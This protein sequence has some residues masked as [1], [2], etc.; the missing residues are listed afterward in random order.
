MAKP[1]LLLVV[2]LA[3]VFLLA[4][5]LAAVLLAGGSA[6]HAHSAPGGAP[7]VVSRPSRVPMPLGADGRPVVLEPGPAR[8]AYLASLRAHLPDSLH[9][10]KRIGAVGTVVDI[11]PSLLRLRLPSVPPAPS[12]TV[13]GVEV[14]SSIG[15]P[16]STVSVGLTRGT[17]FLV[18]HGLQSLA[19][20]SDLVV[21]GVREAEGLRAVLVTDLSTLP[22]APQGS[23]TASAVPASVGSPQLAASRRRVGESLEPTSPAVDQ[24]Q[25]V[26]NGDTVGSGSW[27]W[28][29]FN[30]DITPLKWGD[31]A[32]SCPYL[33]VEAQAEAGFGAEWHFPMTLGLDDQNL[34]TVTS[35]GFPNPGVA[36]GGIDPGAHLTFYSAVGMGASFMLSLGCHV[37][38]PV[39][40]LGFLGK[41]GGETIGPDWGFEIQVGFVLSDAT[42]K[43]A[44]L[45]HDQALQVP[46]TQCITLTSDQIPGL[47]TILDKIH[48]PHADV[49]FC[50]ERFPP[51]D[52]DDGPGANPARDPNASTPREQTSDSAI[53]AR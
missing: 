51:T 2:A 37:K 5:V 15:A 19:A 45:E 34:L 16:G 28:P 17:N 29:G 49:P 42:E 43:P 22:K 35:D 7:R 41:H 1:R 33:T 21:L 44:P 48:G 52:A 27:G 47:G 36:Q 40:D 6:K 11:S 12:G 24:R 25:A 18:A 50:L 31:E 10:P 8:D 4:G 20:G 26:G 30:F 3:A 38:L 14:V 9:P 32:S 23:T 13:G 46:A 53:K 39:V